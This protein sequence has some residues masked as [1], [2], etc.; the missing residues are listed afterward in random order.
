[1]RRRLSRGIE[2]GRVGVDLAHERRV[3][4]EPRQVSVGARRVSVGAR[5]RHWSDEAARVALHTGP[6]CSGAAA[7]SEG[8]SGSVGLKCGRRATVSKGIRGSLS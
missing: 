2:D 3:S 4:V 6:G 5:Q 8:T 1:M 7:G